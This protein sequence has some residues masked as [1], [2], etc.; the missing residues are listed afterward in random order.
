MKLL[1]RVC[2]IVALLIASSSIVFFA[3]P[4]KRKSAQKKDEPKVI[5][6]WQIDMFEGGKGARKDSV[7][8]L[9][10]AY[11]KTQKSLYTSVIEQTVEGAEQKLASGIKPDL[12]SFSA[13]LD[14]VESL[15]KKLPMSDGF[16]G[17]VN[18]DTFAVAWAY[19]GY[20]L[21]S[22]TESYNELFISSGLGY[23]SPCAAAYLSGIDIEN[24]TILPPEEAFSSFEKSENGALIGTQ[25]DLVR[26]ERKNS[27]PV[28][29][30]LGEYTDLVQYMAI[31]AD[32]ENFEASLSFLKYFLS[33]S[34]NETEKLNLLSPYKKQKTSDNQVI[35][36][37]LELKPTKTLY[38]FTPEEVIA[39]LDETFKNSKNKTENQLKIAKCTFKSL[40]IN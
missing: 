29:K 35:A 1:K 32:E 37:L 27:K 10:K 33:E 7:S 36:R 14:G 3:L 9:A 5:T 26:A 23:N 12:I 24:A 11:E 19:G 15:A 4:I 38:A 22:K 16:A 21:I 25:R 6:V 13:G 17:S 18:G 40:K 39:S 30:P 28:I 34:E 20:F 2:F 31:T 8:R